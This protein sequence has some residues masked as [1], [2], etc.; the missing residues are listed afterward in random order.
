[1]ET[2]FTLKS[3]NCSDPSGCNLFN[4]ISTSSGV[5]LLTLSFLKTRNIELSYNVSQNSSW[6]EY[7]YPYITGYCSA[8]PFPIYTG[9]YLLNIKQFE[10]PTGVSIYWY[11]YYKCHKVTFIFSAELLLYSYF[12]L[13]L[14]LRPMGICPHYSPYYFLSQGRTR[15]HQHHD[16]KW[17]R[18]CCLLPLRWFRWTI[19]KGHFMRL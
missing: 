13:L 8:L 16:F 17:T 14:L 12:L 3:T 18:K 2:Y 10:T 1:M 4:F 5:S 6:Y 11:W 15:Q 19:L 7:S 9:T